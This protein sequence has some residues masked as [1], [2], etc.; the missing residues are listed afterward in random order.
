[1]KFKY[2]LVKNI[3]YDDTQFIRYGIAVLDISDT[4]PIV[5]RTVADLVGDAFTAQALANKCNAENISLTA[6][7]AIIDEF[8]SRNEL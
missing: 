2:I 1:M 5:I 7:D 3:Y 6:L 4:P 8:L